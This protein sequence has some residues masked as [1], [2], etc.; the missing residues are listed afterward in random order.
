MATVTL[1]WTEPVKREDGKALTLAEIA[2][3]DV[4]LSINGGAFNKIASVLP[5]ATNTLTQDI[6]V[7]SH[8]A[9]FV[10][11]DKSVPPLRSKN[12]DKPFTLA[13]PLTPPDVV[14]NAVVTVA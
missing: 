4:F 13:A 14:T 7:G 6:P 11:Q 12:M 8:V 3:T 9:R 2:F 1:S 5:A 10:V